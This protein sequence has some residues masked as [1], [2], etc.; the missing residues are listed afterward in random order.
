MPDIRKLAGAHEFA[1]SWHGRPARARGVSDLAPMVISGFN[2]SAHG[3]DARATGWCSGLALILIWAVW[4]AG[5]TVHPAGESAERLSAGNAGQIY[6]HK[7][8]DRPLRPLA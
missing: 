7:F 3:R 4:L 5:C 8:D 1:S 6:V 2:I